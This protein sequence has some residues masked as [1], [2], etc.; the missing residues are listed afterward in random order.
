MLSA[1]QD[2]PRASHYSFLISDL[3]VLQ[4][5]EFRTFACDRTRWVWE[6]APSLSE[7][8]RVARLFA[9]NRVR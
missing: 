9:F 4:T 6:V 8:E 7:R 3:L 2:A 5:S 1:S